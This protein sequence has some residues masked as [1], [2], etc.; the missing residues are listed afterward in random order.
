MCPFL[1]AID[2]RTNIRGK[3]K[4]QSV[5]SQ[6]CLLYCIATDLGKVEFELLAS[7]GRFVQL[8]PGAGGCFGVAEVDA[9]TPEA[10]EQ[11][12][13]HPLIV[14]QEQGLEHLLNKA[15]IERQKQT[16]DE[17]VHNMVSGG[18]CQSMNNT[19]D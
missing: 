9:D 11:L 1:P 19:V 16:T 15:N 2:N 4:S 6:S 13:R 5:G 8:Y 10:L 12:K 7:E 18:K 14:G 3:S 17:V